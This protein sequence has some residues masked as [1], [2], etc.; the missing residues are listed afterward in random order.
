M[1]SPCLVRVCWVGFRFVRFK[2]RPW[3]T[4]ATAV[5]D[6]LADAQ[7]DRRQVQV[8]YMQALSQINFVSV[9]QFLDDLLW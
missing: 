4:L 6:L 7:C 9:Y 8:R 5:V 2:C 1:V 3:I